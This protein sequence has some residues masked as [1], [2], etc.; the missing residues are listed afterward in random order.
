MVLLSVAMVALC[1][2]SAIAVSHPIRY[3][4]ESNTL[5]CESMFEKFLRRRRERN[6]KPESANVR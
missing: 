1:G 5:T 3:D 2:F 6:G 4:A